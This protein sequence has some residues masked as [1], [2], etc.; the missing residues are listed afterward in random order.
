MLEIDLGSY[1]KAIFRI[2]CRLLVVFSFR[3]KATLCRHSRCL[4]VRPSSV[5]IILER[6]SDRSA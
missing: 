1:L 2:F 4:Y 3:K 6:G 5:E